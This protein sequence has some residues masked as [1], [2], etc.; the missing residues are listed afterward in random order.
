MTKARARG[1]KRRAPAKAEDSDLPEAPQNTLAVK[2]KVSLPAAKR[3]PSPRLPETP[4][5]SSSKPSTPSKSS[6]L[7]SKFG[8]KAETPTSEKTEKVKPPTPAKSPLLRASSAS[9][10]KETAFGQ[11]LA[12][13]SPSGER[14]LSLPEPSGSSSRTISGVSPREEFSTPSRRTSAVA[15][16]HEQDEDEEPTGAV[17]RAA[18]W[19]SSESPAI[20]KP[21]SFVSK[22]NGESLKIEATTG[23]LPSVSDDLTSPLEAPRSSEDPSQLFGEFFVGSSVKAPK[24]DLDIMA[25]LSSNRPASA[26]NVKTLKVDLSEITGFGKLQSVPQQLENVLFDESMY[27]CLHVFEATGMR[28]K[29]VYFWSGDKV[30]EPAVEDALLFARKMARDNDGKLVRILFGLVEAARVC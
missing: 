30:S 22:R 17:R 10:L 6:E 15:G 5:K 20:S 24:L 9:N 12:T 1:P 26:E 7:A 14:A 3:V 28:G 19:K 8:Q 4:L 18:S 11:S 2:E 25:I 13:K 21:S 27:V 29:E 23:S 16:V